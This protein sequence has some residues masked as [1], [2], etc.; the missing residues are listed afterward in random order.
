VLRSGVRPRTLILLAPVLFAAHIGEEVLSGYARWYNSVAST[1]IPENGFLGSNFLPFA[2]MA[3]LAIVAAWSM[4]RWAALLLLAW[5]ANFM[6]ANALYH[7]AATVVF[8]KYSPGVITGALFYLPYYAWMCW[9]LTRQRIW[10]I[11]WIA[12]TLVCGWPWFRQGYAVI[13]GSR[14]EAPPRALYRPSRAR[15]SNR[16]CSA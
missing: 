9:Y 12:V 2:I 3:L 6:F 15:S 10:P 4:S 13:R 16:E 5:L 8:R 14:N 7:I 11:V 1:P